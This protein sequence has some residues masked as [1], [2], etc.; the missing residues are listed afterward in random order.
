MNKAYS[1]PRKLS[2]GSLQGL[3]LSLPVTSIYTSGLEEYL[4]NVEKTT[5][6]DD[7]VKTDHKYFIDDL[8]LLIYANKSQGGIAGAQTI[9]DN[10]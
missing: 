2:N 1:K 5:E 8:T 4:E 9:L 10:V 6:D 3:A 7:N